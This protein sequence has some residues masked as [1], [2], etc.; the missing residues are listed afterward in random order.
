[1]SIMTYDQLKHNV[2]ARAKPYIIK[3]MILWYNMY[4][5]V[6]E[7]EI[8]NYYSSLHTILSLSSY[9]INAVH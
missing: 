4:K 1:M 7:L 2:K 9:L 5:Y 3:M 6:T 8:I